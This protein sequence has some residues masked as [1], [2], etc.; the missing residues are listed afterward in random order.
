MK[1]TF[2]TLAAC[3]LIAGCSAPVKSTPTASVPPGPTRFASVTELRDAAVAVGYDCPSWVQDNKVTLAAQSGSCSTA[4]V[5]SIYLTEADTTASVQKL[6]GISGSDV[7]LLVG[8]NWI[9]NTARAGDLQSKMGGT[10]VG[11]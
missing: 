1:R 6:K 7:H 4:D 2:A 10:V 5:L 9:I 11:S 3:L 8:P